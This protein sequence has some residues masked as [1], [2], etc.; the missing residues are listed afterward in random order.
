MTALL[1]L[2]HGVLIQQYLWA[3]SLYSVCDR[4]C[5]EYREDKKWGGEWLSW[6]DVTNA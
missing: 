2:L 6:E 3:S 4:S 1:S 5:G